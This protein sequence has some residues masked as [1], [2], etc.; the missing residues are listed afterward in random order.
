MTKILNV[1]PHNLIFRCEDGSEFTVLPSG[2]TLLAKV[3]EKEVDRDGEISFSTPTF[4]TTPEGEK[5]M[6]EIRDKYPNHIIV[7]S[8]ISAQAYRICGMISAKG[9]E[10]KPP[11]EKRLDP[12]RFTV[13]NV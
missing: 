3:I 10:R 8:M 4:V 12:L 1:T 6:E 9:F 13:F 5:E 11:A 2:Y 7:G